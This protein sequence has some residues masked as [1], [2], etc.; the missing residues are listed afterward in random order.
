MFLY[1]RYIVSKGDTN[2]GLIDAS[3]DGLNDSNDEPVKLSTGELKDAHQTGDEMASEAIEKTFI[4]SEKDDVVQSDENADRNGDTDEDQSIFSSHECSENERKCKVS[5]AIASPQHQRIDQIKADERH[6]DHLPSIVIIEGVLGTDKIL[7]SCSKCSEVDKTENHFQQ[8]REKTFTISYT[9]KDSV[10]GNNGENEIDFALHE[11]MDGDCSVYLKKDSSYVERVSV[12]DSPIQ[13]GDDTDLDFSSELS[14]VSFAE[15]EQHEDEQDNV[16]LSPKAESHNST[17]S[18]EEEL[19]RS[20]TFNDECIDETDNDLDAFVLKNDL[21]ELEGFSTLVHKDSEVMTERSIDITNEQKLDVKGEYISS[22]MESYVGN[23]LA[24]NKEILQIIHPK[25]SDS[26]ELHLD[27]DITE[28]HNLSDKWPG[29]E[30]RDVSPEM[31]MFISEALQDNRDVS[32]VYNIS[33]DDDDKSFHTEQESDRET[34]NKTI[35]NAKEVVKNEGCLVQE[36]NDLMLTKDDQMTTDDGMILNEEVDGFISPEMK[37]FISET[38]R[39]A[40]D[41]SQIYEVSDS[42][43]T[44]SFRT[45]A[46]KR[47]ETEHENVKSKVPKEKSKYFLQKKISIASIVLVE[48]GDFSKE[49]STDNV[50]CSNDDMMCPIPDLVEKEKPVDDCLVCKQADPDYK[51]YKTLSENDLEMVQKEII[52]DTVLGSSIPKESNLDSILDKKESLIADSNNKSLEADN[53]NEKLDAYPFSDNE[54]ADIDTTTNDHVTTEVSA[55]ET[56][57]SHV[58]KSVENEENSE[59]FFHTL[60]VG[61]RKRSISSSHGS[62]TESTG[63]EPGEPVETPDANALSRVTEEL[64]VNKMDDHDASSNRFVNNN[65]DNDDESHMSADIVTREVGFHFFIF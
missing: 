23:V 42:E 44:A 21:S 64:S 2:L 62:I 17:C 45:V 43:E 12:S 5:V 6:I 55:N 53:D 40:K 65:Y 4:N 47:V 36:A 58:Q 37:M 63:A 32:R 57:D 15:D 61:P 10:V 54:T 28:T 13:S 50:S 39:D 14:D 60:P 51:E 20:E 38:L 48:K 33:D 16:V 27:S 49:V 46:D 3:Q 18:A 56:N 11:E 25:E 1:R 52:F 26:E 22:D 59:N 29:I 7:S 34:D 31:K 30:N 41:I 35:A 19:L 24:D 8:N 9:T